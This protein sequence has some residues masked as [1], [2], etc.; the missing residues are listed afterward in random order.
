MTLQ[1]ADYEHKLHT[2]ATDSIRRKRRFKPQAF[3]AKSEVGEESYFHKGSVYWKH[4][5][6]YVKIPFIPWMNIL[7]SK[8][9]F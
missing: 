2:Y 5:P 4:Y 6:C 3:W 7:N 8:V 1:P 9:K